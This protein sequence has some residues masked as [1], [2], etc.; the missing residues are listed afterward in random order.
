M[1]GLLAVARDLHS[2]IVITTIS[3]SSKQFEPSSSSETAIFPLFLVHTPGE[4]VVKL[5]GK[6]VGRRLLV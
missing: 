2:I 1:R 6:L 4:I 5:R 3:T